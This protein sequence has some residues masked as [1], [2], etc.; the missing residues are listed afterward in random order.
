MGHL[1]C[2]G[3]CTW[4]Q[5][6]A[7][8]KAGLV[9]TMG[10]LHLLDFHDGY[11][12]LRAREAPLVPVVLAAARDAGVQDALPAWQGG[13]VLFWGN[14]TS[15]MEKHL[16]T[17][18]STARDISHWVDTVIHGS[19][20]SISLLK[21]LNDRQAILQMRRLR[22]WELLQSVFTGALSGS[23]GRIPHFSFILKYFFLSFFCA[24]FLIFYFLVCFRFF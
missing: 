23:I 16:G 19:F 5:S 9:P 15:N 11:S 12:L 22:L 20:A 18:Q 21:P 24:V 1:L 10:T 17:I 8:S 7:G 3:Y 6:S 13:S 14:R 2:A 4:P